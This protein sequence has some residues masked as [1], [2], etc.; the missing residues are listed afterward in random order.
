MSDG[1]ERVEQAGSS[2]ANPV[3][4]IATLGIAGLVSGLLIVGIYEITLP[5]ITANKTEELREA[6]FQV[7]PGASSLQRL[8]WDGSALAV[9]PDG[10]GDAIF[11]AY[12]DDGKLIGYA[13][14]AEGNGFQDTVALIFG[15]DP[16]KEEIVGMRVLDSRETPGLGDKIVKNEPF[17]ANFDH[18][19]V[20]PSIEL[21]K[22]RKTSPNQVEAITGATISSRAVVKIVTGG[23][24]TWLPRLP[25]PGQEP[26]FQ[27]IAPAGGK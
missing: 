4:M 18:L 24:D 9:T 3:H 8:E 7:V 16:A 19:S 26:A 11:G 17:V 20:K 6:V 27:G 10:K 14:P 23:S 22:T 2:E 13:V 21:T 12:G 1:T 25:P 5:R 15:Y